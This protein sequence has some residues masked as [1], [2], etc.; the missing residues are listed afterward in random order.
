MD[1]N[2][3]GVLDRGSGRPADRA[4]ASGPRSCPSATRRA[5]R[6]VWIRFAVAVVLAITLATALKRYAA[7]PYYVPEDTMADT[8]HVGDRVLVDK[9]AYRAAEPRRGDV[10]VADV[11]GLF[12]PTPETR[13]PEEGLARKLIPVSRW[14]GVDDQQYVV[15]LRVIGQPGDRVGCCDA[16]GRLLVNG[17]PLEEPY[18]DR[19]SPADM[20]PF[21]ISVPR[22]ALF[23]MGDNRDLPPN[24]GRYPVPGIGGVVPLDRVLGRVTLVYWP[25]ADLRVFDASGDRRVG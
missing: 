20:P 16:E 25:L 23:L 19:F 15:A 13:L 22:D 5:P 1:D 17:K 18:V 2:D 11:A 10:V 14:F 9:R 21:A 4:G 7:E 8:L 3:Q 12:T 24:G 6:R